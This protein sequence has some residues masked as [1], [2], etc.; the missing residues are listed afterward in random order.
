MVALSKSLVFGSL[1][2][3]SGRTGNFSRLW[4][5]SSLC[6]KNQQLLAGT[7]FLITW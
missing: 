2:F 7:G 3:V 5:D 1:E 4:Y 6:G